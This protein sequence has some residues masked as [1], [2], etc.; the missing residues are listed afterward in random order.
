MTAPVS[1]GIMGV[2]PPETVAALAPR[3]ERLGFHTLWLN[4]NPGGDSLAGLR[5]AA[6]G[7]TTLRLGSGVIPLDR[8]P[9]DSLDLAGLPADRLIL[10][11]GS[12]GPENALARVRDALD[13]LGQ[14]TTAK[15]V[16][17]ALGPKMRRLAAEHSDG[18]VL[19]WLTPQ[20]A[21]DAVGQLHADAGDREVLG[22]L[23]VRTIVD[24]AVLPALER[25]A[26][27]YTRNPS[28]AANFKR[29]GI[30]PMECTI[31]SAADLPAYREAV[32]EVV[33]RVITDGA[34]RPELEDFVERAA[35][36]VAAAA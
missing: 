15:L 16:V 32:D 35:A 23:Y 5:L 25:E 29:L 4:D 2:T 7:T 24:P 13:S 30:D 27:R 20:A 6:E 14:R 1:I 22:A 9:A 17:G 34:T 8:R 19:N 21:R 10:G 28:Y 3:V 36:W 31:Q 33:L 26:A 12:G 11:V 18:F